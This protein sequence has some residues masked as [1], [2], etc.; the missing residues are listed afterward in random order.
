MLK[1]RERQCY[2]GMEGTVMLEGLNATVNLGPHF[3]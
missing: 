1:R 2:L 3:T